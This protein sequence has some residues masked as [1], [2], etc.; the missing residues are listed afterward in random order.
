MGILGTLIYEEVK[1]KERE[2][3]FE[4]VLNIHTLLSPTPTPLFM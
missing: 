2:D 1:L 3:W 4:P